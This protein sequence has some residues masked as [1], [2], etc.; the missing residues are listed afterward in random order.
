[1]RT[2][3]VIGIAIVFGWI[4]Y[5]GLA[6]EQLASRSTEDW[7]KTLDA[8]AR[9]AGLKVDEVIAHLKLVPGMT[10]ADLGAGTGAF[11]LPF[12]KAVGPT[13]KVY[14]VE[15]DRGLIDHIAGK[16]KAA[17]A[18]NVQAILGAPGDPGLPG[19]VDV[20]FMNDVLHH[21]Q[22]RAGYVKQVA[23][24]LKPR[25]RFVVIDPDT[26]SSPHRGVPTLIVSQTQAGEWLQ[27]AGLVFRAD[28]KLFSD[29]W[30]MIYGTK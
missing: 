18:A 3:L 2:R 26:V 11:A 27:A 6:A 24:Y 7:I 21:V 10:I 1:M 20:A 4:A 23:R 30:F 15:I 14:A 9:I 17:G 5:V 28:I 8:P 13:G 22:D 12:A 19:S 16:A 29:R 25:G